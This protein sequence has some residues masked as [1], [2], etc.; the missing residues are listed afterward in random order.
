MIKMK[1]SAMQCNFQILI[2]GLSDVYKLNGQLNS[3]QDLS[4]FEHHVVNCL[5]SA[6]VDHSSCHKNLDV[7]N[8]SFNSYLPLL[9]LETTGYMLVKTC[10]ITTFPWKYHEN[11]PFVVLD[12]V[13]STNCSRCQMQTQILQRQ[14]DN[15]LFPIVDEWGFLS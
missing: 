9:P 3:Q 4:L 7:F 10:K 15:E 2:V 6:D 11:P 13:K 8:I 5:C 1:S 12:I 14:E